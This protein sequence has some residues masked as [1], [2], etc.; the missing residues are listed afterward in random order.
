MLYH[1]ASAITVA[2]VFALELIAL[3]FCADA[4]AGAGSFF[5]PGTT[6][7]MRVDTPPTDSIAALKTI[8]LPMKGVPLQTPFSQATFP[9]FGGDIFSKWSRVVTEMHA[10]SEVLARCTENMRVCPEP[11]QK[12]LAIIAVGRARSGRAR[13]G[14]INRAVNLAIIPIPM[15]ESPYGNIDVPDRWRAPL[16]SLAGGRGDCKDY[17]IVKYVALIAA[18]VAPENLKLVIVRDLAV[19]NE[20]DKHVVVA[21]HVDGHWLVLDNRWLALAEDNELPRFVPEYLIDHNGVRA[22]RRSTAGAGSAGN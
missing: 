12:L 5:T 20:Q 22:Y 10:E 4:L 1:R 15:D 18:G 13:I 8:D 3:C 6:T 2:A 7:V 16:E 11:A 17:A 21:V 14:V 19:H 9:W